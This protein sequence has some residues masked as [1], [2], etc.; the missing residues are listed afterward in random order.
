MKGYAEFL[1]L[2]HKKSRWSD[3]VKDLDLPLFPGYIFSKFDAHRRFPILAIPGVVSIVGNGR[4]PEPVNES[5]LNAVRRFVESGLSVMPW[6]FLQ[7][8]DL[9]VIERGALAGLE[10]ILVEAKG[11][12]RVVVSVGLLQR[13]VSVEIDRSIV[14]PLPSRK[15]VLTEG[16]L[17][18]IGREDKTRCS[19]GRA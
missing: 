3:R 15:P 16:R 7:P 8:G 14:R 9:V 1:P 13:S 18:D 10:G 11:Q 6:P 2:Y 12:C 17:P 5:E 19:F 4:H